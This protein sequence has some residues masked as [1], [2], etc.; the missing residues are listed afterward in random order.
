MLTIVVPTYTA[1]E[2][3]E[4]MAYD[5]ITT[6]KQQGA[7][8]IICEDG[9]RQSKWLLDLADTYI[10]NTENVGFT[11]NVNRGWKYALADGADYV[12]IVNSDTYWISGVLEDLCVPGKITSPTFENQ[13]F[14]KFQLRGSFF[15]VPRTVSDKYGFLDETM[16]T[17]FSDQ[18]YADRTEKIFQEIE[19]VKI[20]HLC[21]ESMK[22]YAEKDKDDAR[23]KI[24][25]S[26]KNDNAIANHIS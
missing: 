1:N 15:V 9:Q 3:L 6:Y 13:T 12:A 16:K 7:K 19:T 23:D 8:V 21:A 4:R 10:Y 11:R 22:C 24:A 14:K 2:K 18:D 5:F 25:Y 17:Y 20:F 26:V